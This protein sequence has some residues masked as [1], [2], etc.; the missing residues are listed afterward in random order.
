VY[1]HPFRY[2][3]ADTL[4]Q[5]VA[6]LAE[7]GE[8]AKL[9]AGGQS[10]IPLM[11]LRLARPAALIDLNFI[12]GI[13]HIQSRE[14]AIRFGA[15]ARHAEIEVSEAASQ[16]PILHDCA[17]GIADVQVRN[18]GTIGGSVAE[19]DPSGD[20]GAVLL[21]L[22]TQVR[23]L[24]P[25]GER[26]VLLSEFFVDAYTTVLRPAELLQEVIVKLPPKNSGG[27][28][29]AFKRC[30]PVYA[31]ASAAVQLTMADRDTCK[32]AQIALGCVGLTAIRAT[33]AAA[34]LRGQRISPKTIEAAG[35]AAM[36]AAEPQPDMRG[37]AEY[38][39]TL[40]GALVRRAIQV[41]IR[42]SRGE[43]VEVSHEYIG[44]N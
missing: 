32:D 18:R 22:E 34:A 35:E 19:A 7:Q 29:L 42:R 10:L 4:K 5:A 11:K 8:E 40:I 20:W 12:P 26:V 23:C 39:R 21:T 25:Q 6:L 2:F 37:S 28:Y 38:K 3:R 30:A 14:G 27:A 17:A 15:L 24:G 16:I 44:R 41:A 1:T 43:R 9:L 13:S 36:A 31:S 33:D